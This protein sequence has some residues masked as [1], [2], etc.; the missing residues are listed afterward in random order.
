MEK[1]RAAAVIRGGKAREKIEFETAVLSLLARGER[2]I[3]TDHGYDLEE[4]LAEA[5]A[6][7]AEVNIHTSRASGHMPA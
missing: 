3:E 7:L 2:E 1:E 4:V 6:L 5:D